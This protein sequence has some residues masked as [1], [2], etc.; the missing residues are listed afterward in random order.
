MNYIG[1]DVGDGESCVCVLPAGS[2]IEPRPVVITGRRSFL[3]AVASGEDGRPVIGMDAI[4]QTAA[5]DLSVRFKSRFLSGQPDALED[6]GR[7]L[8]GLREALGDTVRPGDRVTVGCPAGWD[9]LARERYLDMI[10]RAGFPEP[11]LVSES[12]G[13]FLYAKHAKTIQLDPA[14]IAKSALVIDIGSSTL[15]FA[16]VVD[17]RETNV[18]VFG[19]VYLGG[20]AVDEA[21]LDAAVRTSPHR[22]E[23]ERVFDQSPA[24]RSHCLLAARRVKEDYFTRQSAG[25]KNIQ[26]QEMV[27][28][29]Y[30]EPVNL[31]IQVNDPL[32]F[33]VIQ[34]KTSALEGRSFAGMLEDALRS[35]AEKTAARPPELVLLTGG[36]SRMGFFQEQ[37][38]KAFAGSVIVVCD[39][40]ELS[41]AKGLA[42]SARV[43]DA[44]LAFNS[45]IDQ[46][47]AGDAVSGAVR[48]RM[49]ELI[50][51]V[52]DHL[53]GLTCAK[54]KE[55][56]ERWKSGG[57]AAL[58]DMN[59][60]VVKAVRQALG[61][62]EEQEALGN[63]VK[64]ELMQVCMALQPQ[65]DGIC[66]QY[67]VAVSQMQLTGV[68]GFQDGIDPKLDLGGELTFL[69]KSV[70]V[71]IVALVGGVL[72]AIPGG[73]IVDVLLFAVAA[74]AVPIMHIPIDQFASRLN[75]PVVLRRLISTGSVVTDSLR[76]RVAK[77]FSDRL[78]DN[79]TFRQSVSEDIEKSIAAYVSGL[80]QRTEIAITSGGTSYE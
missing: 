58:E 71:L 42:Y 80:A 8:K 9:G 29:L 45:A 34:M 41:I 54:L 53:A 22:A 39:E 69:S 47:L 37:C 64:N 16:Y 52:S 20:G 3:S 68:G 28:L 63:V 27:T 65:I 74:V 23:I 11:R 49:D 57:Y 79:G 73:G 19:D 38:A 72:M 24:W 12:R 32:I 77:T 46:Y 56:F 15:D 50:T 76:A 6:M 14:L 5:R 44:I 18:G 67:G 21:I 55:H 2:G 1:I 51:A 78:T 13:A 10:R 48:G 4:G 33:R 26:C 66:Q 36:A 40:P 30:E 62:R 59:G 43:D 60:A 7:F 75:V 25:G 61:G 17:G 70:Q 31:L 35:A